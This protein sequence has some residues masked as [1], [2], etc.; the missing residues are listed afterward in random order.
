MPITQLLIFP[1]KA[2][3]IYS[4]LKKV[5]DFID[6]N[7]PENTA[8]ISFKARVIITELLTNSIKHVGE[9]E[10]GIE[11][12]LNN[13]VFTIKKIDEGPPFNL[14]HNDVDWQLLGEHTTP[15]TI[16]SDALNG[17]YAQIIAPNNLS[18]YAQD[19]PADE[20]GFTDLSEHYGLM[21]IC[22]ASNSFTYRYNPRSGQNIFTVSIKLN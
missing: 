22:R 21:I 13:D 11:L 4:F 2:D 15:I 20:A 9:G 1:N 6:Q 5:V 10:T 17:L 8:D 3:V 12:T 16:Y 19:F 14:K 18:F 7:I